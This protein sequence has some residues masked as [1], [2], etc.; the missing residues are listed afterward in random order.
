M[1]F[2]LSSSFYWSWLEARSW[3]EALQHDSLSTQD[4]QFVDACG[5]ITANAEINP[6]FGGQFLDYFRNGDDPTGT[7]NEGSV[8]GWACTRIG[9]LEKYSAWHSPM[10]LWSVYVFIAVALEECGAIDRSADPKGNCK[11]PSFSVAPDSRA[12]VFVK[13]LSLVVISANPR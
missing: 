3:L 5:S 8:P 11:L 10:I 2:A 12:T 4:E 9:R 7:R 13:K 1:P 6:F